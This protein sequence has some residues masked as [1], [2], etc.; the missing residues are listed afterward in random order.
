MTTHLLINKEKLIESFKFKQ[1]SQINYSKFKTVKE[2]LKEHPEEENTI[3]ILV[4]IFPS[5][6]YDIIINSEAF[7]SGFFFV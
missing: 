5:R 4:G 2:L 1:K 7:Y 3:L 6:L